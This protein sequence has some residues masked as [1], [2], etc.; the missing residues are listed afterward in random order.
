VNEVLRRWPGALAI[1][2]LAV[3]VVWALDAL[4]RGA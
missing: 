4:L 1:G 3:L 2:G